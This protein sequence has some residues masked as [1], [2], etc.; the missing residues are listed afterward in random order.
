MRIARAVCWLAISYTVVG[1][2]EGSLGRRRLRRQGD[3]L[4]EFFPR[5]GRPARPVL[6][7]EQEKET[8]IAAVESPELQS[9]SGTKDGDRIKE[10]PGQPVGID[11]KQYGG[12]VIVDGG[13]GRAL[14]YYLAEAAGGDPSSR[15]L[16]LWFNGGKE[17]V[18]PAPRKSS[19][20]GTR[21]KSSACDL[22]CHPGFLSGPGCS[23]LGFGAME[24]LGPFRVRSDGRTLFRNPFA[25]NSVANVLFLE[26]P[27]GVG[28]SYSNT[29]ADYRSCGDRRS[30]A[31]TL[32]FLVNWL[33]R[34]PEYKRRDLYV[35]GESY[36]GHFVTQLASSS[37]ST[38]SLTTPPSST[39]KE[40]SYMGNA[41]MNDETDFKGMYEFFW[42]HALI[43]DEAIEGIRTFCNF[44]L[45]DLG[46][47]R[48]PDC[49]QALELVDGIFGQSL[50]LYDI[51]G[52]P[53]T[54]GSLTAI[55]RRASVNEF[56]P[57]SDFYVEAYLNRPE[58]QEALHANLTK[59][60]YPGEPA[61]G[62]KDKAKTVL[63]LV[64]KL[65]GHGVRVLVGG[66]VVVYEG[67]LMLA[68]VRGA[69]HEVPSHQPSRALLLV[70]SFLRGKPPPPSS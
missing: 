49:Q 21:W 1:V 63:P 70:K 58:V 37:S 43:S 2:G 46:Y 19:S 61:V 14:F 16:L 4:S 13:A 44:S 52:P 64:R 39:L 41:V 24:E 9:Q 48:S 38:T 30:A 32:V 15:P 45:L 22:V 20:L 12:Y 3:V 40:S 51:Y 31:D 29:T 10:L 11:F 67:G 47:S 23:S 26:S 56:D 5:A 53:C 55:P 7:V 35:A 18:L 36:G 60:G 65:M 50:D 59:L 6:F 66:Y 69:G 42:S 8:A 62:W 54:S 68:T 17:K 27:A 25:W 28:Y 34:F 57:C 33:E